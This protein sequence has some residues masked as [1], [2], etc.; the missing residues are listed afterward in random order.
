VPTATILRVDRTCPE[1][2]AT[3]AADQRYCLECGHRVGE[4]RVDWR[5]LLAGERS[6]VAA[7]APRDARSAR[8]ALPTPRVAATLLLIVM[9][10]GVVVAGAASPSIPNS[11]AAAARGPLTI[12]LPPRAPA[13]TPAAEPETSEAAPE[14]AP[15]PEP[16][17]VEP[18]PTEPATT[19]PEATT[20]DDTL[21]GDGNTG[22]DVPPIHHV[23]LISLGPGTY[24][25][26]FGDTSTVPYLAKELAPQGT[27]LAGYRSTA[28]GELAN[29][30][31]L[32]AGLPANDQTEQNCPAYCPYTI[33]DYTLPDQ[34]VAA[35]STWKAY[36]EGQD[37]TAPGAP[38]QTPPPPQNCRHP[39]HAGD[40]DPFASPDRPG[41]PYVTWR[42]PFV[43]F[44]TITTTPD[45]AAN[46]TGLTA[47]DADLATKK[48]TAT[49]SWLAPAPHNSGPAAADA[50]LRI[51]VPKILGSKAYADGG[52]LAV[53]P[54]A[55][56]TPDDQV[57]G[58]LL[59]SKYAPVGSISTESFDH[60][61]MLKGIEDL[62]SLRYLPGA[63][64]KS[65]KS[66]VSLLL[67]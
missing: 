20:P 17:V 28:Q 19:A 14:P 63:E 47:L 10:F 62:F 13:P 29:E 25:Q 4:L 41:D 8:I 45:C 59:L 42:N 51:V 57:T 21:I 2:R 38:G 36:V 65:V 9:G 61:S 44:P 64:D 43:Y 52:L 6:S 30:I 39:E 50:W 23:F 54:D 26:W 35:G 67:H 33:E 5:G 3:C 32:M 66:F 37:A 34:L 60:F 7:P 11:F 53:V 18:A 55:S 56:G 31:A 22:P 48:D 58:A 1:C 15:A 49:F 40:A 27:L 16:A 46:D 12:V 24:E